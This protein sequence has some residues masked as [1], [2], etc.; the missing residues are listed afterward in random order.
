MIKA[1]HI[2]RVLKKSLF[3]PEEAGSTHFFDT[4]KACFTANSKLALRAQTLNLQPFRFANM[5]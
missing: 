3:L 2:Y 5:C 4:S 1:F